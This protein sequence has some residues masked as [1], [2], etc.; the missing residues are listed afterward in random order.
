MESAREL[1][2][3]G[4]VGSLR[5]SSLNRRLMAEAIGLA[6]ARIRIVAYRGLR[7]IPPYDADIEA[8]GLPPGVTRLKDSIAEA[9]GLLIVTPEYNAGIPASSRTHWT[10]RRDRPTTRCWRG[11]PPRSWEWRPDEEARSG[12]C[13]N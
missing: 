11:S 10:G 8:A 9:D 5:V 12:R 13:A 4:I 3:L 1:L 2:V 7:S 6:P